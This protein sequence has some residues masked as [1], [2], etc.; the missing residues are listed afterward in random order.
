MDLKDPTLLAPHPLNEKLYGM[1]ERN[2]DEHLRDSIKAHG[3]LVPLTIT[4]DN[5]IV[6]GHSRWFWA[7]RFNLKTVPVIVCNAKTEDQIEELIVHSNRQRTKTVEQIAREFTVLERIEAARAKKRLADAGKKSAPGKPAEKGV[8]TIP[9][10]SNDGKSRDLAAAALGISGK[11]AEKAAKVVEKIDELE[12]AGDTDQAQDLRATLNKKGG[13]SEA[14]RK[15]TG[16]A[17]KEPKPKPEK[18][19]PQR[20]DTGGVP[21]EDAEKQQLNKL[22][23]AWK[24]ECAGLWKKTSEYT[25]SA[26]LQWIDAP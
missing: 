3:I 5:V 4:K 17:P 22:K 16:K 6:S 9:Q 11:T 18:T 2:I 26:F 24:Q 1:L 14:H 12:A 7:S 15:A 10:V 13:V 25:K 8:E 19:A 20:D 21:L 23:I